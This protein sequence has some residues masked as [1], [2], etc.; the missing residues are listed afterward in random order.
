MLKREDA[1]REVIGE[2]LGVDVLRV[3][4]SGMKRVKLDDYVT[5]REVL[6]EDGNEIFI[7][8]LEGVLQLLL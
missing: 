5:V 4:P 1:V 7:D 3:Q 8:L 2:H 6:D